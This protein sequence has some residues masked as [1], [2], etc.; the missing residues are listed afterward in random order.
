M[1]ISPPDLKDLRDLL[2]IRSDSFDSLIHDSFDLLSYH[3][4][5]DK[6]QGFLASGPFS[7]EWSRR[8]VSWNQPSMM[9]FMTLR[10][11]C[12]TQSRAQSRPDEL[13][14]PILIPCLN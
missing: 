12:V 14:R 1:C 7:L 10:A 2:M 9:N 13:P 4:E 3:S 6:W 5:V 8:P 11:P